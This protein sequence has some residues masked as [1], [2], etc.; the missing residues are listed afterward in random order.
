MNALLEIFRT[1]S[2]AGTRLQ[3]SKAVVGLYGAPAELTFANLINAHLANL[4][5]DRSKFSLSVSG[6]TFRDLSF[7]KCHFDRVNMRQ[8]LWQHCSFAGTV[9]VPDMTDAVFEDCSFVGAKIRGIAYKYGGRRTKFIRCDF[10]DCVFDHVQILAGRLIEC[11][12]STLRI[13]KSDLRGTFH[14][15]TLLQSDA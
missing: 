9:M 1:K 2:Y 13:I 8:S 10:R 14:D 7:L 3:F 6:G 12:V 15:G 4:E 11:D 5:F